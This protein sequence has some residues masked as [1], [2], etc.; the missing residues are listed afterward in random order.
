MAKGFDPNRQHLRE[1]VAHTAAKLMAEDGIVDFAFAKRKAAR[2]L[3]VTDSGC[4]PG[5]A[6]IDL[7]LRQYQAIYQENEQ[8]QRVMALRQHALDMMKR[9]ERFDPHLFGPVLDGTAGR[10]AEID[11]ALFADSDKEVELFLLAQQMVYERGEKRLR[12][13][14]SVRMVPTFIL[15]DGPAPVETTVLMLEDLRSPPR[16]A[17]DG[18]ALVWARRQQLELLLARGDIQ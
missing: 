16:S 2:Q 4:L 13:G 6:E 14:E 18:K 17:V 5:N 11:L 1:Q 12:F 15:D 7:A 8:P 10:Y 9:L 3:G